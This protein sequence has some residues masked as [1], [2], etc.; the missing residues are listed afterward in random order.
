VLLRAA[1]LRKGDKIVV[2][3]HRRPISAEIES[4]RTTRTRAIVCFTNGSVKTLPA[5]KTYETVR[6]QEDAA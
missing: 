5:G 3:H 6:S 2:L 4:I 1:D